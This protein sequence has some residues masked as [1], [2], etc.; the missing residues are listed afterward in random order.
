MGFV[1][2]VNAWDGVQRR[3]QGGTRRPNIGTMRGIMG[4]KESVARGYIY[5]ARAHSPE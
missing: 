3:E 4:I 5:P 1:D 2:V